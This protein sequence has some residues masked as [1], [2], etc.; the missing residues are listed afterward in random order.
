MRVCVGGAAG[1]CACVCGDLGLRH[2]IGEVVSM[3]GKRGEEVVRG[4]K[5]SVEGETVR[6][7][8]CMRAVTPSHA[9][10]CS[11]C[12][13]CMSHEPT[14]CPSPGQTFESPCPSPQHNNNLRRIAASPVRPSTSLRPSATQALLPPA[15]RTSPRPSASHPSWPRPGRSGRQAG[16]A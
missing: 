14:P 15:P 9:H 8:T 16:T 4:T 13:T 3:C 1:L 6:C 2:A 11:M 7:M 12:M 10:H 5:G